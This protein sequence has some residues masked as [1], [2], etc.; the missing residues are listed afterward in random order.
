MYIIFFSFT[1]NKVHKTKKAQKNLYNQLKFNTS[2][3]TGRF[4]SS[5]HQKWLSY[6]IIGGKT[7]MNVQIDPQT[8]EIWSTKLKMTLGVSDRVRG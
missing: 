5:K 1:I 3:D 7:V 8:S 2:S 6:Q 4:H